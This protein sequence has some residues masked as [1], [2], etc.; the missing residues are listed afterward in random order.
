[1]ANH[2]DRDK[3]V[4][5]L[6]FIQTPPTPN[7]HP[8]RKTPEFTYIHLLLLR[9]KEQNTDVRIHSSLHHLR[10]ISLVTNTCRRLWYQSTSHTTQANTRQQNSKEE[11]QS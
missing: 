6:S 9:L 5:A 10:F 8:N 4:L 7:P 2:D 3:P 1:M 11:K